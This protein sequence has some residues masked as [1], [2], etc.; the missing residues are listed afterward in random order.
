MNQGLNIVPLRKIQG[1]L[2]RAIFGSA[3]LLPVKPRHVGD[4]NKSSLPP[5]GEEIVKLFLPLTTG[6]DITQDPCRRS[7]LFESLYQSTNYTIRL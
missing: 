2:H 5:C 6:L 7:L 3:M 1:L 4:A